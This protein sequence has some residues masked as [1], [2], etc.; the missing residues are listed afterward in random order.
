MQVPAHVLVAGR[1][2][3]QQEVQVLEMRA[4]LRQQT[5]L[6]LQVLLLLQ[7]KQPPPLRLWQLR[8]QG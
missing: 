1:P 2:L 8:W 6:L 4:P 3:Q 7:P 5:L